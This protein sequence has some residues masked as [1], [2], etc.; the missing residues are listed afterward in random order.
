MSD[1]EG[2][3]FAA[4]VRAAHKSEPRDETKGQDWLDGYDDERAEMDR[5]GFDA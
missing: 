5:A 4:G 1:R 2:W 3:D